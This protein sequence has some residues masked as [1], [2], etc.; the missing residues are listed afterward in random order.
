M[1]NFEA[2]SF[3]LY[4]GCGVVAGSLLAFSAAVRFGFQN[5]LAPRVCHRP[6]DVIKNVLKRP[7]WFHFIP[8][9]LNLSYKEMLIGIEGTGTRDNGWQGSKLKVSIYWRLLSHVLSFQR[10]RRSLTFWV[11][12]VN[13]DGVIL[14]KFHA[15][16]LKVVIFATF[17]CCV[18]LLPLNVTASANCKSVVGEEECSR[19]SNLNSFEKTTLSAIPGLEV[20]RKEGEGLKIRDFFSSEPGITSKL[21]GV[22]AVAWF[23]YIYTCGKFQVI[24]WKTHTQRDTH[25]SVA[26]AHIK[27]LLAFITRQQS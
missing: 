10:N 5:Q 23:I 4:V 17:I 12:K 19:I 16:C 14:I 9:T 18:V 26:L 25:L 1:S 7:Y 13:L 8:W 11:R 20:E 21:F 22:V 3:N 2:I 15:L 6:N 24:K 27:S